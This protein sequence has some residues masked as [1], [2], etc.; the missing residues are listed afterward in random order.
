MTVDLCAQNPDGSAYLDDRT[1]LQ[2][3]L[4]GVF[5]S[6]DELPP[7]PVEEEQ[8]LIYASLA[9]DNEAFVTLVRLYAPKLRKLAAPYRAATSLWEDTLDAVISGFWVAIAE[10]DPAKSPRLGWFVWPAVHEVLHEDRDPMSVALTVPGRTLR[11]ASDVSRR[12]RN[13]ATLDQAIEEVKDIDK[14]T[15]LS[16]ESA[17]NMSGFRDTDSH[18][19]EHVA[20]DRYNSAHAALAHVDARKRTVCRWYYGFNSTDPLLSDAETAYQM[21]AA[22]LGEDRA[23]AGQSVISRATVQRERIAA[24][25]EMKE[26]LADGEQ[27]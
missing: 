1:E 18:E 10:F 19:P 23:K 26:F 9:G 14:E 3:V 8:A 22:E 21:S 4:N 7:V 11:R 5:E 12:V 15:Y 16:V 20:L 17:R 25:K 27:D 6:R 13:G 24:L 2:K